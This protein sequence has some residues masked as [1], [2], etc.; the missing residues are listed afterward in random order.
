MPC[1]HCYMC[2]NRVSAEF[3]Q[4]I[5]R[6]VVAETLSYRDIVLTNNLCFGLYSAKVAW[7]VMII[8][9]LRRNHKIN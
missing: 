1:D 9:V 6:H 3:K 2:E 7:S 5:L 8:L 4:R